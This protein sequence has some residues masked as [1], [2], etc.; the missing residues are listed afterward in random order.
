MKKMR[1]QY[2]EDR[3]ICLKNPFD[4]DD[5]QMLLIIEFDRFSA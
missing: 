1:F 3:F 4:S 5:K 2:D